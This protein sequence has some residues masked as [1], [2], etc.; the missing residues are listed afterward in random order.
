MIERRPIEELNETVRADAEAAMRL[1]QS[2]VNMIAKIEQLGGGID[3]TMARIEHFINY[4][5]GIGEI[6]EAQAW[7]EQLGWERNLRPQLQSSLQVVQSLAAENARQAAQ[8]KL[9]VPGR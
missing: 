3:L 9:I 2:N 5:V 6:S 4:L 7:Q 8:P 1:R